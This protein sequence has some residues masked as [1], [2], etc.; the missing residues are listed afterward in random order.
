MRGIESGDSSDY[1]YRPSATLNNN[2]PYD[3]PLNV[4][5]NTDK[6]NPSSPTT[7]SSLANRRSSFKKS[8]STADDCGMN[9]SNCNREQ[10]AFMDKLNSIIRTKDQLFGASG[11]EAPVKPQTFEARSYIEA[12]KINFG[13]M[14]SDEVLVADCR[15]VEIAKKKVS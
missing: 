12:G 3:S 1:M 10:D 5:S 15:L 13:K 6:E 7:P 14:M 9:V 4:E 8:Y 11:K 2:N